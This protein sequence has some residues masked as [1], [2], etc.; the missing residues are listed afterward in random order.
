MGPVEPRRFFIG[1]LGFGFQLVG[2]LF[3][4]TFLLLVF[5][6]FLRKGPT[7]SG[8]ERSTANSMR[9]ILVLTA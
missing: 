7:L 5:A 3:D 9:C 4:V 8:G 1:G 2:G 6:D